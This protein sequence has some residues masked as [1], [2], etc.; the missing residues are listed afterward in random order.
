MASPSSRYSLHPRPH[1][2]PISRTLDQLTGLGFRNVEA[3]TCQGR[4][5]RAAQ[6]VRRRGD[7]RGGSH[8]H[9]LPTSCTS[10]TSIEVPEYEQVLD[11]AGAWRP[12]SSRRWSRPDRWTTPDVARTAER[13][14]A[15]AER[16]RS[17]ASASA[18]CSSHE[19][20]RSF[21]GVACKAFRRQLPTTSW[22][23]S[24]RS[25]PDRRTDARPDRPAQRAGQAMHVR[26]ASSRTTRSARAANA[27]QAGAYREGDVPLDEA[28]GATARSWRRV[29][30]ATTATSSRASRAP[31]TSSPSGG[32][33]W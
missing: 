8:A 24:T 6:G 1:W 29:R 7:A 21:D 20:R 5:A 12:T 3:S 9:F 32:S 17:A 26:T 11:D 18:T 22:S 23:S 25:G 33:G 10:A 4:A 31:S 13:L 27:D 2:S 16:P 28:L 14:N 19:F 30:R 15:A